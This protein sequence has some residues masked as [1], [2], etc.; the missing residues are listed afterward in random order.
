MGTGPGRTLKNLENLDDCRCLSPFFNLARNSR[1]LFFPD[2]PGQRVTLSICLA[3]FTQPQRAKH[4]S[5]RCS[6]LL[7]G[8]VRCHIS[9]FGLAGRARL[10]PSLYILAQN[11]SAGASPSRILNCDRALAPSRRTFQSHRDHRFHCHQPEQPGARSTCAPQ[12]HLL[13]ENCHASFR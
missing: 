10:L 9:V 13:L 6:T 1:I 5:H 7:C 11:G 4:A 3:R 2:V 8:P 12:P